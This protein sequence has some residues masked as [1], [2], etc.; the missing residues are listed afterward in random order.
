MLFAHASIRQ[1][2]FSAW[3][4]SPACVTPSEKINSLSS[5]SVLNSLRSILRSGQLAETMSFFSCV[6]SMPLR[7][8]MYF[9]SWP[10]ISKIVSTSAAKCVAPAA[11][12]EISLYTCAVPR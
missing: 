11:C 9:A 5:G 10:P 6:M 12:A 4:P 2:N 8:W 1:P 3:V 7:R